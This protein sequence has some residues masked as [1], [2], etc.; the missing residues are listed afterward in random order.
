MVSAST[1]EMRGAAS[2]SMLW[3]LMVSALR[4][5]FAAASSGN[6]VRPAM[7]FMMKMCW[8]VECIYVVREEMQET[9]RTSKWMG[10][11]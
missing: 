5:G 9:R 10:G 11:R 4:T 1:D 8:N 2:M 3:W 6:S 7:P